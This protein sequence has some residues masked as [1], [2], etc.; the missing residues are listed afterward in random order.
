MDAFLVLFPGAVALK[1]VAEDVERETMRMIDEERYAIG[2]PGKTL[3]REDTQMPGI[4]MLAWG[5]GG[6]G[7]LGRLSIVLLLGLFIVGLVLLVRRL[8]DPGRSWS[9]AGLGGAPRE[10]PK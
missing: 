3:T 1:R 2:P 7:S 5:W 8:Q 4:E 10:I 6:M 9:G